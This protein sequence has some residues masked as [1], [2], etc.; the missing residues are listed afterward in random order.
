MYSYEFK[1][2]A[3]KQLKK[4]DKAVQRK[5]IEHLDKISI[6]EV[7]LRTKR[8]SSFKLGSFRLRVGDYRIVYDIEGKMITILLLG[9][10]KEIYK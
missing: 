10:R 5:I 9:H 8:L 1:P 7:L 6:E 4:L 2:K 3:L